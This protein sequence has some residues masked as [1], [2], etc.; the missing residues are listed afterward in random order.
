MKAIGMGLRISAGAAILA[1]TIYLILSVPGVL[2]DRDSSVPIQPAQADPPV[3]AAATRHS[4]RQRDKHHRE[5][6]NTARPHRRTGGAV[7]PADVHEVALAGQ[8]A[9]AVG[10]TKVSSEASGMSR[11]VHGTNDVGR[12]G[13]RYAAGGTP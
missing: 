9:A 11:D 3:G 10:M 12:G 8:T 5:T 4:N 7:R 2:S 6:L 13:C 1:A